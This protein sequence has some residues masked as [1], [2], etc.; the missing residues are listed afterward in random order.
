MSQPAR[1]GAWLLALVASLLIAG[2]AGA[3]DAGRRAT[4]SDVFDSLFGSDPAAERSGEAGDGLALP[5]LFESGREIVDALPLHD[6]GPGEGPCITLEPLLDALELAHEPDPAGGISVTLPQPERRITI[7]SEALIPSPVGDCLPMAEIDRHLPLSLAY[8]P[9]SQRLDITANAPLP[10]L[11]RLDREA[12][13]KRL[14]PSRDARPDFALAERE[15]RIAQLWSADVTAGLVHNAGETQA[16]LALLASGEVFGLGAR[17]SASR[18][19]DGTSAFGL[20]LSEARSDPTLLGPLGARSLALGDIA[21]PAQ[22]LI[23]DVLVGRGLVIASRPTWRADLVDTI[24]LSGPLPTGW[25]AE[26]WHEDRLVAVTR[27]A[28]AAGSWR[29]TD[30]PVRLGENRWVVKLHGPHGELREEVFNR[31]VGTEMHAENELEYSIGLIDAGTPLLGETVGRTPAGPAAFASVGYGLANDVTARLDLRAP[32]AG[33]RPA[34]ALGLNGAKWGGLWAASVARDSQGS[35]GAAMRLA[36]RFG[37]QDVVFDLAKHG[38]DDGVH[39]PGLV[40]EF[41]GLVSLEG[42]GRIG[43]GKLSLPWQLRLRSAQRRSGGEQQSLA[44]RIALPLGGVQANAGA[45]LVREDD[46]EWRGNAGLG[47]A[48][49]IGKWRL[50]G[51]IDA[52]KGDQWRLGSARM[53]A[54]RSVGSGAL[55]LDVDWQ[56]DNGSFGAGL[57]LAQQIGDFGLSGSVAHGPQGFRAGLTLNVGLWRHG[58]RWR[59]APSGVSRSASLVAEMFVDEDGDGIWDEGERAVEGGRFVV[60]STIRPE[61]TGKDGA[62]LIRGLPAGPE[63]DVETQLASLT[64]FTLRPA[65]A[66]DRLELRPGEVRALSVPLRP[67]GSLEVAVMLQVGDD[68]FGRS[69]VEVVLTD[70]NG[71]EAARA[72]TDFAGYVLFEGLAYGTYRA[73][74]AGQAQG[75]LALTRDEP[76]GAATLLIPTEPA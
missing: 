13:Y 69:G 12:S 32:L 50:R 10:V 58:R 20:T 21:T 75:S 38:R 1:L 63:V 71:R 29:F 26:L 45:A 52:I 41:S 17:A 16:N 53:S 6:L 36:R 28:D 67:T 25:E 49:R 55:A 72:F 62:V 46:G 19:G 40:R 51:G 68:R 15:E 27:E 74:A 60:G 22:P 5:A 56:A 14:R 8:D 48:G 2:A 30:L 11:M 42:Q 73:E 35:L 24:E 76:D 59:T 7:P 57:S 54:V 31:L 65:R 44:G 64:D 9:V 47:L 18:G 23:A 61:E 33:D 3:Q 37:S 39:L 34:L 66:G 43:L 4:G 70:E